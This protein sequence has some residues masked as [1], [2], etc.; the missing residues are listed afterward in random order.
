MIDP[1][2][3]FITNNKYLI[4]F[5]IFLFSTYYLKSQVAKLVDGFF[6]I[7]NLKATLFIVLVLMIFLVTN[8]FYCFV[9]IDVDLVPPYMVAM[10]AILASIVAI[11]NIINNNIK[12]IIDRSDKVISLTSEGIIKIDILLRNIYVYKKIM[13]DKI[14]PK[15]NILVGNGILFDDM[16]KY[17][18]S[19]NFVRFITNDNVE[20]VHEAYDG[21]FI[22]NFFNK[23]VIDE[24]E[25]IEKNLELFQTERTPFYN[26][27]RKK[28]LDKTIQNL[29]KL[30]KLMIEIR[31]NETKEHQKIYEEQQRR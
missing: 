8:T 27:E 20:I 24:I 10:S 30:K 21:V 4:I 28:G 9:Q 29:E 17:L 15:K 18:T 26:D 19:E 31:E 1:V 16:L 5:I 11:I 22:Q 7:K 14:V 12:N 3:S 6:T 23:D 2:N 13:L 25:K